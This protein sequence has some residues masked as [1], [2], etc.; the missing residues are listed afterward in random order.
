MKDNKDYLAN[1]YYLN[2]KDIFAIK[3]HN[4][5]VEKNTSLLKFYEENDLDYSLSQEEYVETV[6]KMLEHL[7]TSIIISRL[8][9][10]G[11]R[12]I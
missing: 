11:I 1:I 4:L 9:V 12:K 2:T 6:V 5:Y 7:K 10:D 3:I 8:I